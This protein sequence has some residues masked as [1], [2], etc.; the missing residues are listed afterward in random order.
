MVRAHQGKDF[1]RRIEVKITQYSPANRT[2]VTTR[3]LGGQFG[4]VLHA[5]AAQLNVRSGGVSTCPIDA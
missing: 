5:W 3:T 4:G 1:L 2:F